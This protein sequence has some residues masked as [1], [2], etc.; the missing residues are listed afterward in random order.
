MGLKENTVKK[1]DFIEIKFV[2]YNFQLRK[3]R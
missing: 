1:R 2:R 3:Y